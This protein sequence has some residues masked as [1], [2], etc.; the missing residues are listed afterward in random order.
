MNLTFGQSGTRPYGVLTVTETSVDAVNN[1]SILSI[2][3]VL[4]RPYSITSSVTKSASCTI[5]G[6]TY[7]WSGTIGGSGDLTLISKTQT[8]PHNA[9]GTKS[10]SISASIE[11]DLTWSGASV[12]TIS[13]SDTMTLTKITRYASITQTVVSKTENT[14]AMKWN[15]DSVVDYIWYSTNDGSTWHGINVAD[16]TSGSYTI[17]NLYA[18][19]TY[20]IRTRIRNKS[21]QLTTD[22]TKL[23]V[24]TYAYPYANSMPNFTIGSAL[25]IGVFN[26][27]GHTVTIDLIGADGAI[28]AS[29][30]LSGTSITGF[31]DE[32]TQ[33]KLYASIPNAKSGTY[34][35]KITYGDKISTVNGGTYT[36]NQNV[37]NPIIGEVSYR[38]TNSDTI[39]LTENVQ[40]VIKGHSIVGY[41]ASGLTAM[42]SATI[43]SCAVAVNGKSFDLVVNG[44]SASGVGGIIES[45]NNVD[46]VFI[47][48]D[49]R[50]LTVT[51][52]I[53]VRMLDWINPTAIVELKRHN[54]FYS[55]TDIKVDADYSNINGNNQVTITWNAKKSG[56]NQYSASGT[57]QNNITTVITL[58]NAYAWD[59]D[60]TITD[61]LGGMAYYSAN[62]A[63]GMPIIYFDRILSAVGI[64][65][66][67]TKEKAFMIEGIDLIYRSGDILDVSS[68]ICENGYVSNLSKELLFSIHMPKIMGNVTPRI[69]KLCLNVR[70]ASGSYLFGSYA[71][72]GTDVT[73]T[74]GLTV[75]ATK[76]TDNI[77]TVNVTS[78][79]AWNATNNTPAS[80]AIESMTIEFD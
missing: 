25:K 67:P 69:T 35:I 63:V 62:I 61:K 3:L 11:L 5:N 48:T 14:V 6:A 80:I 54:N 31:N 10:I 27:L 60:I 53:S 8:I 66:F 47:V 42:K 19:S 74:N 12:G 68:R 16:G 56:S 9:D 44:D 2:K 76:A 17:N 58:D 41:N 37:C 36:I 20:N 46:A 40:D 65:C 7:T 73:K 34:Q 22:S 79:T 39:A 50:G 4:K 1:T 38:D 26:P 71:Y 28:C 24:N 51:K 55:E 33:D 45:S 70:T 49:S 57:V 32:T 29:N 13:G 75:T 64:N 15:S 23:T 72:Y 77:I 43:T 21:T 78:N 59:V 18:N 30:T 52:S